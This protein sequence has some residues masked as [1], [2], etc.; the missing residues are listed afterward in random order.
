MMASARLST[1]HS[2]N[3]PACPHTEF[4]DSTETLS[5]KTTKVKRKKKEIEINSKVGRST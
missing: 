4:Q 1:Q 2:A 3:S 5:Y